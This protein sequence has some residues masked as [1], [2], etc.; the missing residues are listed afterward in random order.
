MPY[1]TII[2]VQDLADH[3]HDPKWVT[4]DARFDI[5]SEEE[6]KRAYLVEHIAGARQADLADHMAGE[7]IPGKSGRRPLPPRDAFERTIREWGINNDTQ[8]V[9]YDSMNGIMTAARLWVMLNWAGH[10]KVALLDGGYQAWLAA[11]LPVSSEVSTPPTGTFT[12]NYRPELIAE[13]AEVE[14]ATHE[15]SVLLFDSRSLSDGI[16]SHDSIRGR[17]PS[18]GIAD[19]ALNSTTDG[20]WRSAEELRVHYG[21][22]L[23]QTPPEQVIFYCGSGV[24]A[25]QNLVGMAHAGFRGAKMYPGSWSQWILDPKRQIQEY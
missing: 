4:L 22:L 6:A 15:P 12:A 1:E 3:L 13:L 21:A 9:I 2:S 19:R 20:R 16:P 8:V 14:A 25:A 11:G 7:I 24:T 23:S 18:S 5:D 10:S 17:I